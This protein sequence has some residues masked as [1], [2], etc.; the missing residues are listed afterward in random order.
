MNERELAMSHTHAR[1]IQDALIDAADAPVRS[2]PGTPGSGVPA[3]LEV[4]ATRKVR[5]GAVVDDRRIPGAFHP[6]TADRAIRVQPRCDAMLRR[7]VR[8][9]A[10]DGGVQVRAIGPVDSMRA[11]DHV[12][13]GNRAANVHT[14]RVARME[15]G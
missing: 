14:M 7:N 3:E 10:A 13:L 1:A 2:T 9:G 12:E 11:I 5:M 8:P 15:A 6:S 4:K